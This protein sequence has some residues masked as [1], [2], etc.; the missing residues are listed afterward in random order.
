M[1]LYDVALDQRLMAVPVEIGAA[2]RPASPQGLFKMRVLPVKG[3]GDR[4][5]T[6]R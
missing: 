6:F 4:E 2:F 3:G 1:E 5:R